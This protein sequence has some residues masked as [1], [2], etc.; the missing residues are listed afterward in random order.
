MKGEDRW[1]R[2]GEMTE[3][4]RGK[5]K[6]MENLQNAF[7]KELGVSQFIPPSL[8][9]LRPFHFLPEDH[10]VSREA[11]ILF[12]GLFKSEDSPIGVC[13]ETGHP[14]EG[15][16]LEEDQHRATISKAGERRM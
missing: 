9:P 6:G 4:L 5:R 10:R 14:A 16:L 1:R 3:L 2:D 7:T 11:S 8:L 15:G 12:N 13:L